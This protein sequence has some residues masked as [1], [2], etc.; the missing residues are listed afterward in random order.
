MLA[1]K[2]VDLLD[3]ESADL[4]VDWTVDMTVDKLVVWMV[5]D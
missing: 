5:E 4:K 3:S 1:E 2:M